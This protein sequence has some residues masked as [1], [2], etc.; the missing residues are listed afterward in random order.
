MSFIEIA[1]Q[2]NA[3]AVLD[4]LS[5][6]ETEPESD[7]NLYG[8]LDSEDSESSRD[9]CDDKPENEENSESDDNDANLDDSSEESSGE[10]KE[11]PEDTTVTRGRGPGRRR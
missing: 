2:V 7:D 9:E 5:E 1:T 11:E 10:S 6:V 8:N 3:D 4:M